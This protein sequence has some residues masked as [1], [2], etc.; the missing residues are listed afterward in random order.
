MLRCCDW[1]GTLCD[2]EECDDP[3]VAAR[4]DDPDARGIDNPV[5]EAAGGHIHACCAPH[6]LYWESG[7]FATSL[8]GKTSE[9]HYPDAPGREIRDRRGPDRRQWRRQLGSH[10]N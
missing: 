10:N 3:Q 4:M 1:C 7:E 8:E 2:R 9:G 5:D 6:I